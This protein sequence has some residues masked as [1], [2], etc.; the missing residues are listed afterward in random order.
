MHSK[1]VI[2]LE[3]LDKVI[4]A[5]GY[6]SRREVKELARRG[7]I[8]VDGAP[9]LSPDIKVDPATSRI[10]VDGSVLGYTQHTYLLLHKPAGLLTATEDS[11]QKT[12]M[13]LLPQEYRRRDL[14]PV[15]RLDKDTEGLLLLTN[16]GELNHRL[17]S[18]KYHVDKTYYAKVEGT[19]SAKDVEAFARGISLKDFTCLP[20]KLEILSPSEC[21]VTV[22]EGKF[23]QVK[24]ML[25]SCGT[26]VTYLKRLTMGPLRLDDTLSAGSFREL[27]GEEA[28]SLRG[29]CGL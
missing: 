22:G 5:M 7:R 27:T 12:V 20:A 24:R 4:A 15:G 1:E 16:D 10:E 25:A 3:R 2:H 9:A 6:L 26:P 8:V 23:H 19:L 14:F 21:I 28:E 13:D 17:T 29:C 18:P 11:R